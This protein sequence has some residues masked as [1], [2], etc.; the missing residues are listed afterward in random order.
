MRKQ[1][2]PQQLRTRTLQ[3]RTLNL[4]L[5]FGGLRTTEA[6]QLDREATNPAPDG[7]TWTFTV[8]IKQHHDM[9]EVVIHK[10]ADPRLD[11]ITHLLEVRRRARLTGSTSRSFWIRDNGTELSEKCMRT[12]AAK[13]LQEANLDEPCSYHLKH[14]A[15][16]DLI[17][18]G[19]AMH[20]IRSQFRHK[21]ASTAVMDH[22]IDAHSNRECK[23][24]LEE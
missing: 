24:L 11:P 5:S 9:E 1:P 15:A 10:H 18:R 14:M 4:L 21:Q 20:K 13:S 8:L 19:V 16:T 17:D 6:A 23:E 7:A 2:T 3:G 12:A 22:Y